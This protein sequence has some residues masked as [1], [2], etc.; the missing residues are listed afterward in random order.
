MMKREM[1]MKITLK[2]MCG[3]S[4]IVLEVSQSRQNRARIAHY[5]R[6]FLAASKAGRQAQKRIQSAANAMDSGK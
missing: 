2:D 5:V 1:D 4:P 3:H 6:C